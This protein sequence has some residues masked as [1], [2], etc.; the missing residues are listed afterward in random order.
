MQD[1]FGFDVAHFFKGIEIATERTH[2]ALRHGF[3]VQVVAD[4]TRGFG[5]ST[6]VEIFDDLVKPNEHR[7]VA[8]GPFDFL[9]HVDNP[10]H[11]I[12]N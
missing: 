8:F 3:I 10:F 6:C 1:F 5:I 12:I 7:D 11:H 9:G 4:F 2:C